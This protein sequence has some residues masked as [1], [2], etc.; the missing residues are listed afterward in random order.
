MQS[1]HYFA[2]GFAYAL[3]KAQTFDIP[4][5]GDDLGEMIEFLSP[6]A[7]NQVL[8]VEKEEISSDPETEPGLDVP[9]AT[10]SQKLSDPFNEV[11]Q[12]GAAAQEEPTSHASPE[13]MK[14]EDGSSASDSMPAGG[15]KSAEEAAGGAEDTNDA[16]GLVAPPAAPQRGSSKPAEEEAR[17]LESCLEVPAEKKSLSR[18]ASGVPKSSEA[19][20]QDQAKGAGADQPSIGTDTLPNADEGKLKEPQALNLTSSGITGVDRPAEDAIAPQAILK[21]EADTAGKAVA[22][23]DQKPRSA[24]RLKS[25]CHF[26][27]NPDS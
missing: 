13:V 21:A 17:N 19:L 23:T 16:P 14:Q 27:S 26:T 7:V 12:P 3:A 2:V 20:S 6:P 15:A 9:I 1:C 5:P 22:I 8:D 11:Y 25:T 10:T 18:E 24:R 4:L